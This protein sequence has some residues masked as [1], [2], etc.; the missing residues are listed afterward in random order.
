MKTPLWT[1][2]EETIRNANITRFLDQVNK[3]CLEK[4]FLISTFIEKVA[5]LIGNRG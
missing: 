4:P 3:P 1:P 2:K 5:Q